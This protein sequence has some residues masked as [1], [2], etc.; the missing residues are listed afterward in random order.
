M[1]RTKTSISELLN[2][3]KRELQRDAHIISQWEKQKYFTK[4]LYH[5]TKIQK[6]LRKN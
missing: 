1:V 3:V 4:M 6:E 2:C 5:V